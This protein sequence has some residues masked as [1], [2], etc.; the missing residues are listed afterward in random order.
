MRALI[1]PFFLSFAFLFANVNAQD[2]KLKVDV[3]PFD[4][5][6]EEVKLVISTD[7]ENDIPQ[8]LYLS[9]KHNIY[10]PPGN[11]YFLTYRVNGFIDHTVQVDIP[12]NLDKKKTV[13]YD[14]IL[15]PQMSGELTLEYSKPVG[16]V[17]FDKEFH[18]IVKFDYDI[19]VI[20]KFDNE[21]SSKVTSSIN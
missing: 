2:V 10:L 17:T 14:L 15:Y 20:S 3:I 19:E 5:G 21:L 12:L 18:A 6:F 7:S 8:K 9:D 1:T 4:G 13:S 11:T 16:H